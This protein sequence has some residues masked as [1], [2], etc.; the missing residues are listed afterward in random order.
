MPDVTIRRIRADEGALLRDVRLRAFADAPEAFGT[1][2]AEASAL[3]SEWWEARAAVCAE[4]DDRSL[5]VAEVEGRWGGLVGAEPAEDP[6]SDVE[7][8]SMWVDPTLRGRHLGRRFLETVA[9]WT[10]QHNGVALQLWVTEGNIPAIRLYEAY[11]F[12]FTGN[13]QPHPSQPGLRELHMRH[14]M[15]AVAPT[16]RNA[17]PARMTGAPEPSIVIRRIRADEAAPYRAI[18]LRA[19]TGEPLAF[20]TMLDEALAWPPSWWDDRVVACAQGDMSAL[21][22]AETA[23]GLCGLIGGGRAEEAGRF[24]V[25]SMW[26]DPPARRLGLA[27]RLL[28]AVTAWAV[29]SGATALHL[30]VTEGN[31]GA[32]ALY[33]SS[34]FAFTGEVEPLPGRPQYREFHMHRVL[35]VATASHDASGATVGP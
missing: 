27:R 19:L 22:V 13:V 20:G 24:D 34:G 1:T 3:P 35:P 11:G 9:A 15:T 32:I 8:I 28:D 25:G 29:E 17:A 2:V 6:S 10:L 21:F 16:P 31:D 30:T 18:R 23:E 4:D 12:A 33:E 14:S 7:V 5:W 26:I